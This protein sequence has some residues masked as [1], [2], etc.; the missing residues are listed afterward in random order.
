MLGAAFL[1]SYEQGRAATLAILFHE[2]PHEI[3]DVAVLM[4]SG[5]PK[6]TAIRA[7]LATAVGALLGTAL[8]LLTGQASADMLLNFTAGGFVYVACVDLLPDL[9]RAPCAARQTLAEAAAL[10]AGVG[11]MALVTLLE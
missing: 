7:Q 3:G 6:W 11:M 5:F 2:I 10:S 4:Q 9:L 1:T 8:A